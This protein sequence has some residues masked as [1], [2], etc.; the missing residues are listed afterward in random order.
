M[1]PRR[2]GKNLSEEVKRA[3][4]P[5]AVET[6]VRGYKKAMKL[7]DATALPHESFTLN[8][9]SYEALGFS[10]KPEPPRHKAVASV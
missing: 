8:A 3:A 6:H 2:A 5:C 7:G 4:T 10:R 1:G 9:L